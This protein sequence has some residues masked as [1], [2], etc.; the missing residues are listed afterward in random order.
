MTLKEGD[1]AYIALKLLLK[2]CT[3]AGE[4]TGVLYGN[5]QVEHVGRDR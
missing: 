5:V 1:V 4:T 2:T 3:V